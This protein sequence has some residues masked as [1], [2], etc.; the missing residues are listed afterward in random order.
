MGLGS[1]QSP[2]RLPI[3]QSG[4]LH[5]ACGD[6]CRYD[7]LLHT[8]TLTDDWIAMVTDFGLPRVALPRLNEAV[9]G[10]TVTPPNMKRR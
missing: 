8:K 6:P 10:R 2:D 5:R 1:S 4:L 7:R 3:S 9:S